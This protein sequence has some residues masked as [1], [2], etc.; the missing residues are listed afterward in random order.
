MTLAEQLQGL[1]SYK[2]HKIVKASKIIAMEL[3]HDHGA[4]VELED[5]DGVI[6]LAG[7]FV[8]RHKPAVGMFIVLY[9]D[10][11]VSV[12]PARALETGY[13]RL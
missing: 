6:T 3:I 11:Y 1:P 4:S 7:D 10:D 8:L 2:C 5:H 9:E 13:T 12:S